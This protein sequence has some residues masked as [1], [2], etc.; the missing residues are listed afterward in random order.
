MEQNIDPSKTVVN[1]IPINPKNALISLSDFEK[2][3]NSQQTTGINVLPIFAP[4]QS[5]LAG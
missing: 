2:T 4:P 1:P 5:L 3:V